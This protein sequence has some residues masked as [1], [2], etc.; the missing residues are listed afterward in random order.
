MTKLN[1]NHINLLSSPT[2]QT[3][4]HGSQFITAFVVVFFS[5][6]ESA[7]ATNPLHNEFLQCSFRETKICC[8]PALSLDIAFQLF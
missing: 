8:K 7:I 3:V 2:S 6:Q 4:V 1:S 5:L